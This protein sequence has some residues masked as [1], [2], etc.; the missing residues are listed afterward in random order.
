MSSDAATIGLL[1]FLGFIGLA[2][3]V[4]AV[5]RFWLVEGTLDFGP[6]VAVLSALAI[7]S[8]WAFKSASPP[9]L[10]VWVAAMFGGS[11][12]LPAITGALEK[13]ALHRFFEEDIA[14]QMRAI[15]RDALNAGAWREIGELNLKMNRYDEAIAAFQEAI[16]INPHDV[17]SI[18]RRLKLAIDYRAGM[19]NAPTI[20][21]P[22]CHHET[23]KGK[24]CIHCRAALEMSFW[25]WFSSAQNFEDALK[26]LGAIGAGAI[27]VVTIFSPLPIGFK[28]VVIGA[29]VVIG[30]FLVWWIVTEE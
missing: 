2:I 12:L 13:R 30:G 11:L 24:H 20:V 18:Q 8:I 25:D 27:A 29:C 22:A 15:E 17:Q 5:L 9:V 23:P 3:A 7:G 28:A 6:A 16:K 21:C 14:K 10:A 26:P 19:P 1:S 4:F